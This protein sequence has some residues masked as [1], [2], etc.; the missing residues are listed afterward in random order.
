MSSQ[1][2]VEADADKPRRLTSRYASI[3]LATWSARCCA[4]AIST[5]RFLRS[6]PEILVLTTEQLLRQI[7]LPGYRGLCEAGYGASIVVQALREGWIPAPR[8]GRGQAGIISRGKAV[9]KQ[10]RI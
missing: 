4:R 3:R 2:D 7:E 10:E 1:Q 8:S 5:A 6:E 9:R